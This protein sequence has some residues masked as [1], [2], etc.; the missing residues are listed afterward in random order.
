MQFICMYIYIHY[1]SYNVYY[2][3][4][5]CNKYTILILCLEIHI[6]ARKGRVGRLADG[7]SEGERE[8]ESTMPFTPNQFWQFARSQTNTQTHRHT[9]HNPQLHLKHT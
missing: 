8:R 3:C 2:I 5:L 9:T 6:H 7:E 1:T 4:I